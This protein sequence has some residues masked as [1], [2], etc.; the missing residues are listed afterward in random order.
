[1][2][3]C[4]TMWLLLTAVSQCELCDEVTR[5]ETTDQGGQNANTYLPCSAPHLHLW[6]G[7]DSRMRGG[8]RRR[9]GRD[10][11]GSGGGRGGGRIITPSFTNS[12]PIFVSDLPHLGQQVDRQK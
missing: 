10:R 6:S 8:K 7:I 1:M 2:L 5:E 4:G 3:S 9:R 11:R 12:T